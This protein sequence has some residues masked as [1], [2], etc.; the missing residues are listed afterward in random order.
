MRTKLSEWIDKT[1][2]TVH[3][4]DLFHINEQV[5]QD[6]KGNKLRQIV[7]ELKKEQGYKKSWTDD[8]IRDLWEKQIKEITGDS[9]LKL[10]IKS[11]EGNENKYLGGMA[12]KDGKVEF[13]EVRDKVYNYRFHLEIIKNEGKNA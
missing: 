1:F 6:K 8:D 4:R 12:N 7:I 13:V 2:G 5:G 11:S 9:L 3:P 10:E